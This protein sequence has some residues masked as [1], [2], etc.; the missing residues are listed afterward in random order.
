MAVSSPVLS[1]VQ[2]MTNKKINNPAI[3]PIRTRFVNDALLKHLDAVII[4]QPKPLFLLQIAV[5][6]LKMQVA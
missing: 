4:L 5:I 6:I 1:P 2:P 3:M